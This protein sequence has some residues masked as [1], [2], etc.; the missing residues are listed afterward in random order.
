MQLESEAAGNTVLGIS[1][2]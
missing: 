2:F 1:P